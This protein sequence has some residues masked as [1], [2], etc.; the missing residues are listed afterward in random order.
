MIRTAEDKSF[1]GLFR[2]LA[3]LRAERCHISYMDEY[4][5]KNVKKFVDNGENFV[6]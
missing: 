5:K 1:C 2:L 6:V 4:V 3:D